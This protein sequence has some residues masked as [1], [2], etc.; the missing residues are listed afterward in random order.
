MR[1]SKNTELGDLGLS[2]RISVLIVAQDHP[3]S[4]PY[5]GSPELDAH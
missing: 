5:L 3:D 2:L 1:H 4:Q